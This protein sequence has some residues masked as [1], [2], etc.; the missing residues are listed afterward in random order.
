LRIVHISVLEDHC[1]TGNQYFWLPLELR[2][3]P[4]LWICGR[5]S[6]RRMR[7]RSRAHSTTHA[8]PLT[9]PPCP[10]LCVHRNCKSCP[11]ITDIWLIIYA[12]QVCTLTSSS[13]SEELSCFHLQRN[14]R[15]ETKRTCVCVC[16]CV[17]ARL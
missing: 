12:L 3:G 13:F 6:D 15:K 5:T 2:S 10:F 7:P 11:I 14:I 4:D 1:R 16:V 8:A 17:C 9:A